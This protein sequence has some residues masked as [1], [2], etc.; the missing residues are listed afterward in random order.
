MGVVVE[1]PD[2]V[3][4]L[5]VVELVVVE[6]VVVELVVVDSVFVVVDVSQHGTYPDSAA[7][8]AVPHH[9]KQTTAEATVSDRVCEMRA[10]EES[11]LEAG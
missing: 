9:K 5:V 10:I 1:V 6:L 11:S 4:E 8:M 7:P 3:V 2:V